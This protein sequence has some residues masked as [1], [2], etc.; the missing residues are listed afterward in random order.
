MR[1]A[2]N[3]PLLGLEEMI[4]FCVMWLYML[5]AVL[6]SR[7]R[8][9]LSADFVSAFI[10]NVRIKNALQMTAKLVSMVAVV[11]FVVW[12][13]DLLHWGLTMQQ[14]T[15][16]FRLPLYLSQASVFVASLCF[17]LYQL[18]DLI[19]DLVDHSEKSAEIG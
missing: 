15:P 17:L 7:D 11:A 16:V 9:H 6:A 19:S 13:F 5:G 14:S 3:A 18:R 1:S 4:L 2:F 8:S 10:H 12:S